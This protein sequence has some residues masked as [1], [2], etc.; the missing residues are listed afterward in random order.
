MTPAGWCLAPGITLMHRWWDDACVVYFA[1]P[2]DT[3]LVDA[4]GLAVLQALGQNVQ[5]PVALVDL[6]CATACDEDRDAAGLLLADLLGQMHKAG[7]VDPV[8]DE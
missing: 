5:T 2:G 6:V 7:L 1:G 8:D 3:H 4:V